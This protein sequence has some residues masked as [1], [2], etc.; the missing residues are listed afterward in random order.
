MMKKTILLL[1]VCLS[2]GWL[3]ANHWTPDDSTY[4]DN[5]T[6]T[7]VVQINGVE[8]QSTTLEVGVFCGEECRGSGMLTY[9]FP[10]QRYVVQLLIFGEA[11][12]QLTFK[13]YD[14]ALGQEL[15]MV[16]QNTVTF[17]SD[18]YGSLSNP[19]MLNFIGSGNHWIPNES[20]YEDNMTLTGVIQINGVEQSSTTLEV[21][22]FC[23]EECRGTGKPTYFFPTQRYVVQLLIF[24]EAGDQLTFKL[25]DHA[26]GQELDLTSP[27][28][29][30]FTANGYGSLG[31]PYVLN[32]GLSSVTQTIT[33]AEGWNWFSTYIEIT[34]PIEM[35]QTLEAALGENGLQIKNSNISTEYD[36]EWG[37]F[38]DLDEVG[39]TNEEMIMIK[40]TNACTFELQGLPAHP[41]SHP[42]TIYPGWNWIGY[43]CAE[44]MTLNQAFSNFTPEEGDQI[45]NSEGSSEY[46]A[47]WG[48]FGDVETL[49]PGHGFMYY[50]S[51]AA[52][53]TLVFQ[54]GRK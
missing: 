17:S 28:A 15:N 43:P 37:W 4:E 51:S 25:Y 42:I 52:T 48:W 21:G 11:G 32:F 47:E 30:T 33:L 31:N 22:V 2:N 38:G 40:A 26:I 39:F 13:L 50:S 41:A 23:G 19:Y 7:G 16:S 8:Q 18:G 12:D 35:L 44:E 27:D 1:L 14:H 29:V 6:L 3:F 46:D 53:K 49:V 5:M 10:T 24:G 54:V 34:N 36:S 45:K 9:F 20:G